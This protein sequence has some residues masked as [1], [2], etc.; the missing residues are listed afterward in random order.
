MAMYKLAQ[1]LNNKDLNLILTTKLV[2]LVNFA[3]QFLVN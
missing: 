2:P 1:G 3:S